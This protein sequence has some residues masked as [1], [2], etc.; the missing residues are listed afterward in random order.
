VATPSHRRAAPTP[1]SE[2]LVPGEDI[3]AATI[4][5]AGADGSLGIERSIEIRDDQ[6]RGGSR[7]HLGLV[8]WFAIVWTALILFCAIAADALPLNDPHQ[9]LAGTPLRGPSLDHPFGTDVVGHDL[10]SQV[11]HGA[12]ISVVVGAASV[13]AGLLV[14][15]TLGIAAGLYRGPVDGIVM[16][17]T[18]VLL[19]FP[20][21]VLVLAL[22]SFAGASLTSVVFAIALLSIPA[23]TRI[24]RAGTLVFSQHNSVLAARV[25][26]AKPSRIIVREIAPNVLVP[27]VPFAALGAGVAIIAEGA[28]SFLGLG[29]PGSRSWG[30]MIAQGQN[31]LR[32]APQAAFAPMTVMFLTILALNIIGER[33][34]A[35]LDPRGSKL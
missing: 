4:T 25:L 9:Q 17:S 11:I 15:G 10:F 6:E 27:L 30:S 35:S 13:A 31:Q 7:Q 28:L 24:A 26:G 23:Y 29:V 5:A 32:I 14:G 34:G 12:Q 16:W 33:L 20:A 21:L 1:A 3:G 19:A 8:F 2:P 22:V 18:D